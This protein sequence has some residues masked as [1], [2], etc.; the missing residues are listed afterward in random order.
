MAEC[1]SAL[2]GHGRRS[3]RPACAWFTA[4]FVEKN[5]P[6]PAAILARFQRLRA[7]SLAGH[8]APDSL[9]QGASQARALSGISTV[10][11]LDVLAISAPTVTMPDARYT[12]RQP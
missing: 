11:R 8:T 1:R 5:G 6:N 12:A 7:S 9:A 2:S 3:T 10:L 4:A